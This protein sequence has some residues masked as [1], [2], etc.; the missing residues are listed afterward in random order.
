MTASRSAPEVA[1][2]AREPL[3]VLIVE[4][5]APQTDLVIR[6]LSRAG[7][8]PEWQRVDHEPAYVE[9]LAAS[10]DVVLSE[11]SLPRFGAARALDLLRERVRDI[12]FIVVSGTVGEEVIVGLM[13]RGA[14]DYVSKDRLTRLGP[15]VRRALDE[16]RLRA[17]ERQAEAALRQ[18]EAQYRNL[19]DSVPVGLCRT[20]SAGEFVDANPA[21][22]H[23]V[24]YPSLDALRSI[25][26]AS[27]YAD[28]ADRERW[29][30]LLERDGLITDF[31]L[32]LR[33]GDGALVW[34]RASA[35]AVLD[36]VDQ[37]VRY[38]KVLID[39]T[40]RKRAEEE[41][42]RRAGQL[43]IFADVGKRLRE[44]D[45]VEQMYPIVVERAMH[46]LRA[47]HGT[48]NLM[49]TDRQLL[50]CVY[51][52]GVMQE[53]VGTTFPVAGSHSGSVIATGTPYVT[54]AVGN[55]PQLPWLRRAY[56]DI[57]G[58]VAIVP[59]RSER[60]V[61]GTLCVGRAKDAGGPFT[62]AE[63]RLL[64]A[65]AEIG[66]TAIRRAQLHDNLEQA[67][68]QMVLALAR[69]VDARDSYTGT[70]SEHLAVWTELVARELG[71]GEDEIRAIRWGALLH[72]IG[73]IGVPDEIL[74]KP[75]PLTEDEWNVMRKH[76]A[77]GEEILRPVDRMS[78]VAAL[79]RHHQERWDGSG[80]P[81]GLRGDAIPLG[82]RIVAVG[83][84]YS[85][86]MDDRAYRKGR[87]REG[88]L[89]DLR[90]GAG[91]QFDPQVVEVFCRVVQQDIPFGDTPRPA[92][93]RSSDTAVRP[94]VQAI[95]RS[96]T[97]ARQAGRAMPAMADVAKRLL[98]PLDLSAVLDEILSQIQEVFAY[99][100][101]SI[102][103]LDEHTHELRVAAHRGYAPAPTEAT[104]LLMGTQGIAGWVA[105][106]GRSYYAADVTRDPLYVP[107]AGEAASEVGYPLTGD[108]RVIG[109]LSVASP[110]G[111]AFPQDVREPLE[112]FATLAALAILR[113]KRDD[114][115]HRLAL[116]DGL[117][118]LANHRALW[119]ALERET[120]QAE[121]HNHPISVVMVEIDRF[122]L[123]NDHFGHLQGD[124]ILRAVADVLKTHTR[125][126]DLA[127]RF[128]GDEFMLLLPTAPKAAAVQIAERIR[129]HVQEIPGPTGVRLTVS[130]GLASMPE[131][132]RTA[133]AL[134][135]AADRA[136]YEA[137][138]IG[139]NCVNIA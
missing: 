61:V 79:V 104:L 21:F 114:D 31:E 69:T 28:P 51:T 8:A 35:R 24:G 9:G 77:I 59:M 133:S 101:C 131:D 57:L 87:T 26:A 65:V 102:L 44:A 110:A 64:E 76:P 73:K 4:D 19:V 97:Q 37:I 105:R 56:Y 25:T 50:T 53:V 136:M 62:D 135:E 6:A 2:P 117:T 116:T 115:L 11:L 66:G 81:D 122:K 3:R 121:R 98:R 67:Y 32:Q 71:C 139:G 16:R 75:G 120:A 95:A 109:V 92:S 124:A 132:G 14:A 23:I 127:A 107:G 43:E 1:S 93:V 125:A 38:E 103:L 84:A 137:K 119:D 129:H 5:Q 42:A 72:D 47:E 78:P 108:G 48:L 85:A 113:A 83:D 63:L 126:G 128:G 100:M 22:L 99:S 134:V 90:R 74:R 89:D 10:P 7:F 15:A 49:D 27:L 80:Y 55:E 36:P 88:A 96:L 58:P 30:T 18:T 91:T 111:D 45:H 86:M 52:T 106:H 20:T 40:N 138:Y 94:A 112:T 46:L 130:I 68:I 33:R 17:R 82:A 13:R 12:P 118:G 54:D 60:A 123:T 34:V 29:R 41:T 70:H 39:I